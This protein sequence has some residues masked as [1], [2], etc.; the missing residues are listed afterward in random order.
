[1][2]TGS[3]VASGSVPGRRKVENEENTEKWPNVPCHSCR[4]ALAT[5]SR[6]S[7]PHFHLPLVVSGAVGAVGSWGRA[8]DAQCLA[9]LLLTPCWL[10]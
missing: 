7:L 5:L 6:V 4:G 10:M 9:L 1:M 8:G 3:T 2:H